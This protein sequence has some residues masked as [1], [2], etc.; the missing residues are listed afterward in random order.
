M[1]TVNVWGVYDKPIIDATALSAKHSTNCRRGSIGLGLTGKLPTAVRIMKKLSC[2]A[3]LMLGCCA[4]AVDPTH[5]AGTAMSV[6]LTNLTSP[7]LLRGFQRVSLQPGESKQVLFTVPDE[8]L[9]FWNTDAKRFARQPG[10]WDIQ[11]GASSSDIRLKASFTKFDKRKST[12][13]N[14]NKQYIES[15]TTAVHPTGGMQR[16]GSIRGQSE[17]GTTCGHA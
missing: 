1:K 9:A 4:L 5:R 11:V 2:L 16:D 12:G 8:K 7:V 14:A 15:Y 10:Q 17:C 13:F 6:D 3:L